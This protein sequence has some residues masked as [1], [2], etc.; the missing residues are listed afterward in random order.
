M[1]QLALLDQLEEEEEIVS[2][3]NKK[4]AIST[5]NSYIKGSP[6]G[7]AAS[8]RQGT[9]NQKESVSLQHN[10]KSKHDDKS[11]HVPKKSYSSHSNSSVSTSSIKAG[12]TILSPRQ[13]VLVSQ[14][15]NSSKIS[16]DA[17]HAKSTAVSGFSKY[18]GAKSTLMS[19]Q[20]HSAVDKNSLVS[21]R[22]KHQ[23]VNSSSSNYVNDNSSTDRIK[24]SPIRSTNAPGLTRNENTASMLSLAIAASSNNTQN[25][26]NEMSSNNNHADKQFDRNGLKHI[27]STNATT[28]V[29]VDPIFEKNKKAQSERVLDVGHSTE[30]ERRRT[31]TK[32]EEQYMKISH[33]DAVLSNAGKNAISSDIMRHRDS[34]SETESGPNQAGKS[35]L[36]K[37]NRKYEIYIYNL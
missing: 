37:L 30:R 3:S 33:T 27:K 7:S 13:N 28:D 5:S 22:G 9:R 25:R 35:V 2:K 12:N 4:N 14:S 8:P 17:I 24:V 26:Y 11:D 19:N 31:E 15:E 18:E 20:N 10:M 34:D 16:K 32:D 21:P 29:R 6:R 36:S 1:K 23:P